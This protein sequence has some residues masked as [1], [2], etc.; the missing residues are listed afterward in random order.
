[1]RKDSADVITESG[2]DLLV[3][4]HVLPQLMELFAGDTQQALSQQK[5]LIEHIATCHYCRTAV[6]V[7]LSYAQEYDRRY[8]PEEPAQDLL[9][10]FATI[11][12]KIEAREA[13]E[14]E[15]LGAYAETIVNEGQEKAAQRFPDIAAH[16]NNCSDC[17]RTIEATIAF[18]TGTE[19]T[20]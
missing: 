8:N 5:Q 3:S 10:R 7:L 14:F 20:G 16:L 12:R 1:M 19:E 18:I 2:P 15:R 17:R 13:R 6:M 9:E 4:P 11:S